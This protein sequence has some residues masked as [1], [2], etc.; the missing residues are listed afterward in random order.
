MKSAPDSTKIWSRRGKNMAA[1]RSCA[2][3]YNNTT[4][5]TFTTH[6]HYSHHNSNICKLLSHTTYDLFRFLR[7]END[8][9]P[10]LDLRKTLKHNTKGN[11]FLK[12]AHVT[13]ISGILGNFEYLNLL[14]NFGNFGDCFVTLWISGTLGGYFLEIFRMCRIFRISRRGK[15][16]F[17]K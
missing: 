12:T 3:L 8:P 4:R 13:K 7:W 14:W 5:K 1:I 6:L 10:P 9:N 15:C 2:T 17:L 11:F 16:R